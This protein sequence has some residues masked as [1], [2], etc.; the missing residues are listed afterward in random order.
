MPPLKL[1]IESLPKEQGFLKFVRLS[2]GVIIL[3]LWHF[4]ANPVFHSR[5]KHFKL[6][7]YFVHERVMDKLQLV[8]HVPSSEH[9]ADIQTKLL[10][11]VSFNKLRK[12]LT[13]EISS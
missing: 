10:P 4:S 8:N 1:W 5:S 11:A 12:K 9:V 2:F 3:V 7:L 13:A 6:D